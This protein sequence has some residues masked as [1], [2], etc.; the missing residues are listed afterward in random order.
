MFDDLGTAM[1]K[2]AL[3]EFA[4]L[5]GKKFKA[6]LKNDNKRLHFKILNTG[7]K[8]DLKFKDSGSSLSNIV[9]GI[10]FLIN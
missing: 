4:P 6:H 1:G 9:T 5:F 3:T 10:P 7:I 2:D 8:A